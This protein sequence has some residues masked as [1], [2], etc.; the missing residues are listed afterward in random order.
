M[1]CNNFF[2]NNNNW[3]GIKLVLKSNWFKIFY[4]IEVVKIQ[5]NGLK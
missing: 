3:N 2:L 4:E 5:K 1:I